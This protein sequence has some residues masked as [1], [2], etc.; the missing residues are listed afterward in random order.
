MLQV[1]YCNLNLIGEIMK[2]ENWYKGGKLVWGNIYGNPRFED[3]T[4]VHTSTVLKVEG[5]TITTKNSVYELG[6]IDKGYKSLI[7][8]SYDHDNPLKTSI[9]SFLLPKTINSI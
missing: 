8:D 3:G 9:Y 2:L 1:M 7:G 6:E 4:W 5:R